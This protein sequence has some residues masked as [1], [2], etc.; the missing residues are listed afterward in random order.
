MNFP[1]TLEQDRKFD[2][3]PL[4]NVL[5]VCDQNLKQTSQ[6]FIGQF[7]NNNSDKELPELG[8]ETVDA[9]QLVTF[10]LASPGYAGRWGLEL[11]LG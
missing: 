4:D 9:A 6:N 10:L 1:W 2:V 5:G 7:D 11:G 8:M 3:T